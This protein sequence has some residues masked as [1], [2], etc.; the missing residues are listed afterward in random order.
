MYLITIV[1]NNRPTK[2]YADDLSKVTSFINA[3]HPECTV[4]E[5]LPE[6]AEPKE[7]KGGDHE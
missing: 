6:F 1:D 7:P 3:Y 4:V 2:F 5:P